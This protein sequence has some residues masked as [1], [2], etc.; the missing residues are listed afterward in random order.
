MTN[1]PRS[2]I[3]LFGTYL[4]LL[5]LLEVRTQI[6]NTISGTY[7]IGATMDMTSRVGKEARVAMEIAVEDFNT[8]TQTNMTLYTRNSKGKVVQ[9]IQDGNVIYAY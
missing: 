6:G 3:L 7:I 4:F 2:T 8:K 9:A 5:N 1:I